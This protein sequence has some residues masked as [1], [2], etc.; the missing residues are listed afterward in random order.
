MR[1]TI[2]RV[3][4][5]IGLAALALSAL[6]ASPAVARPA[7]VSGADTLVVVAKQGASDAAVRAAITRANG[8]VTRANTDVGVYTV[9]TYSATF[10]NAV[11]AAP[12]IEGVASDRSIGYAPRERRKGDDVEKA[13]G[14]GAP[15][16]R[17][18]DPAAPFVGAEPL[19]S[20]Q[21]DMAM[22][23]SAEANAAGATGRRVRVGIMDTGVDATHPDIRANFDHRLSRNFTVDDPIIDGECATDPDGSC[24]DPPTVD[25][26][27]HGTHVAG[28][29]ASPRNGVGIAGIAPRARIVNLRVGQD[30]GYFFL[31][32]TVDA[33]TYAGDNGID[34]VNMSYYIDPWL[35]NCAANPA[36]SP[37]EQAEQRTIITATNRAL[38]YAR[39]NGV[40]LVAA[41][42]NE[43]TDLDNRT[44]DASSPDYPPGTER[45][46]V[47]DNSCLS[48][49]SEGEGV[50]GVSSLGPSKLKA[51]YSNWG[52]GAIAVSAP[53][54][55][56]RDGFGTP[57]YRTVGNLILSPM[58]KSVGIEQG[59][60]DPVSG[61]PVDDFVVKQC[62]ASGECGYY[63]Y[64]QGT[65]MASPHAAGVAALIVGRY[66]ERDRRTGGVK[67][68]PRTTERIL[69]KT[70]TD[71]A[72]PAP[73][74]D[75]PDRDE[76]YTSSCVGD[77]D[78]NSWYGDGIVDA[79]A[80][81]SL[82][83]GRK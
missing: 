56:F 8:R 69:R 11:A 57:T 27:G 1:S 17:T 75:Y 80:A 71:T 20:L 61:E 48:M 22:L 6:A 52:T 78:F 35:Y 47:V 31:Q 44:F 14:E 21:W 19:E 5:V 38:R 29:I 7:D 49:P 77:A 59:L 26:D 45:D 32:P 40:T 81:V 4:A 39:R 9:T 55:Y 28:T 16:G 66:G 42:G 72:C 15:R 62:S 64:L 23:R 33:L 3:A 41:A 53:G 25:E 67:L 13:R 51:D 2:R 12:V 73:V 68:N 50:I 70:A 34:V 83:R 58:P 43:N 63:Q 74:W 65:S 76:T 10:A 36:D 82:P 54:G 46:R 79:L 24:E 30:S 37:A 18:Y 60:I